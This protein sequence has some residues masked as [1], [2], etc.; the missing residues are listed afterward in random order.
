MRGIFVVSRITSAGLELTRLIPILAG[1]AF[2][3]STL[4]P[5]DMGPLAEMLVESTVPISV[6]LP[7]RPP[8]SP[9]SAYARSRTDCS[10]PSL[11][12]ELPFT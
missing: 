7:L 1:P 12:S 2:D 11:V 8:S 4:L 9:Q 10:R 3:A 5:Q 6:G